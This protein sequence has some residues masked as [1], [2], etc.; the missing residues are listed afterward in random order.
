V[1]AVGSNRAGITVILSFSTLILQG[2]RD[3]G[4]GI[5]LLSQFILLHREKGK[6]TSFCDGKSFAWYNC[7]LTSRGYLVSTQLKNE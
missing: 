7:H 3:K 6:R 4:V 2:E 1:E 5:T